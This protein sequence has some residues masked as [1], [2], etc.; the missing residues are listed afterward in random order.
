MKTSP[1]HYA[2]RANQTK[3][4]ELLLIAKA[5]P[6]TRNWRG[7]E[8]IHYACWKSVAHLETL[9][10]A[11][12]SLYP[13]TGGDL[14][15][16]SVFNDRAAITRFLI[17]KGLDPDLN[18]ANGNTPLFTAI[19][20]L[21]HEC[22]AVLLAASVNITHVNI[23]GATVLHLTASWGDNRIIDTL[24][25][26]QIRGLDIQ[27]IDM[28]GRSPMQ[29]L[30]SRPNRPSGLDES[31]ARLLANIEAA[32]IEDNDSEVFLDADDGLH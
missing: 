3:G 27:A 31:F 23:S 29:V 12:A 32:D 8:P 9:L 19:S 7:E 30:E 26:S 22:L 2:A 5:N 18:D 10:L 14:I 28:K 6:R 1:V 13:G 11:G 24:L 21:A 16:W 20:S 15:T 25:R 17:D 4:L